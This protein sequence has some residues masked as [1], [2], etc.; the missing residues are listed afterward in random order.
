MFKN[1]SVLALRI[2]ASPMNGRGGCQIIGEIY[3]RLSDLDN[4]IKW[5]GIALKSNKYGDIQLEKQIREQ[6]QLVSEGK[7]KIS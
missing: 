5:Y 1:T 3:R 6:W 7:R 2:K 4:A